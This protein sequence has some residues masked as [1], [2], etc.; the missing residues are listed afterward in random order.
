[1][2]YSYLKDTILN[3]YIPSSLTEDLFLKRCK[4]CDWVDK[5]LTIDFFLSY[6]TVDEQLACK[7][8]KFLM[9][10]IPGCT[11]YIYAIDIKTLKNTKDVSID[12]IRE[13]LNKSKFILFLQSENSINSFWCAWE[14]GYM[15][16]FGPEKCIVI[17]INNSESFI[18]HR[19]F[20]KLYPRF[21]VATKLNKKTHEKECVLFVLRPDEKIGILLKNFLDGEKDFLTKTYL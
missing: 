6:S 10:Q 1:M 19:E 14:L 5:S 15:T 17:R 20:L 3:N 11:I 7:F 2:G 4:E 13:I 18:S 21:M 8:A 9:D 12:R 16:A